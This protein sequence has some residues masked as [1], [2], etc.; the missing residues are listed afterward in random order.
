MSKKYV[1]GLDIGTTSAKAVIF[2]LTGKLVAEDEKLLTSYYPNPG[3][4]EQD[5]HEIEKASVQAIRD[6]ITKANIQANEMITLGIS[7]AMH[8]LLCIDDKGHPLS[9]ALIWADGRSSKQAENLLQTSGIEIYSRTGT[10]IHPMTPFIKLVWMK[11]NS[12]EP[13]QR[14]SYFLSA[15]EYLLYK[16]FGKRLIDYSM[17]SAT[18]FF[19]GHL[20]QWDEEALHIAGITKQQLSD[21]VPPTEVLSG[22][23]PDI[24]NE[25][26]ISANM[27]FVIGSADGQL[28]NLGIGAISPGEVAVTAGTSGAIRQFTNGFHTNQKHE[29]FCYRFTQ[30]YSIVGGP[31]NNGGIALQWLKEV[32]KHEGSY[33]EF[34]EEANLVPPGSDGVI[35]LPY[36]NGERAPLWN[37]HAK[38]NFFG[39]TLAHKRE[40]FIRAVLEG[41]TFN[42]HQIGKS[43]E[44]QAGEPVK[45]YVNGGMA[46]SKLWLQMMADVFGKEVYISES[47][48]SA[49]WGAAWTALVAIGEV[50]SFEEI[51]NNIPMGEPIIPNHENHAIYKSIY[52]KYEKLVESI[53]TQF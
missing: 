43:L 1:I 39:L 45:I 8:S 44:Q 6:V 13:Y 50:G 27:P 18:G 15:K 14:A 51:K 21:I 31:T 33:D 4:V 23:N 25:M 37:Q 9:K 34:L 40:H 30:D 20:L 49:A 5:P 52:K 16:W 42:L 38:G 48:H 24:A 29:T 26:G 32:L 7:S 36:V 47:H 2:D 53:S 10:P 17:A 3:W 28:A 46:R 12:Y 19:N 11:E 35:F 41:I 22:L